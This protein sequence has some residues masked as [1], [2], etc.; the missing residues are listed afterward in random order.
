MIT[1]VS[2]DELEKLSVKAD[3]YFDRSDLPLEVYETFLEV[4]VAYWTFMQ[5]NPDCYG[6]KATWDR[7]SVINHYIRYILML[8]ISDHLEREQFSKY[9]T[10]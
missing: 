6:D 4:Q 1:V 10:G 3:S 5:E 9:K 7:A 8:M 2:V